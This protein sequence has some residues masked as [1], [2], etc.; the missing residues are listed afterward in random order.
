MWQFFQWFQNK[1]LL[2]A[3]ILIIES[4]MKAKTK[5]QK[6]ISKF[7]PP[8]PKVPDKDLQNYIYLDCIFTHHTIPKYNKYI[9]ILNVPSKKT[10]KS[11]G[12]SNKII[13]LALKLL[14]FYLY[15]IF[16]ARFALRFH[17]SYCK[18]LITIMLHKPAEER[19]WLYPDQIL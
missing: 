2:W 10:P 1:I 9:T 5:A 3:P 19:N 14:I 18:N 8:P 4:E 6:F 7:F 12:I 17:P 11:D 16:N 13:Y 15:Q